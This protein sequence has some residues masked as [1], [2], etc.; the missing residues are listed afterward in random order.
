MFGGSCRGLKV[1]TK[2]LNYHFP[3]I[4]RLVIYELIEHFIAGEKT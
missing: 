3:S 4:F 1:M 2:L